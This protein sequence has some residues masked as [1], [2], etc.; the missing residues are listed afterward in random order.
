MNDFP[1]YEIDPYLMNVDDLVMGGVP[2]TH[3]VPFFAP[4][5]EHDILTALGYDMPPEI[6]YDWKEYLQERIKATMLIDSTDEIRNQV[7]RLSGPSDAQ[8]Y[9]EFLKFVVFFSSNGFFNLSDGSKILDW[10]TRQTKTLLNNIMQLNL[11]SVQAFLQCLIGLAM[12][13]NDKSAGRFLL[14]CDKRQRLFQGHTDQL[15]LAAVRFDHLTLV[16]SLLNMKLDVNAIYKESKRESTLLSNA[17]SVDMVNMLIQAGA[18]VNAVSPRYDRLI[19]RDWTPLFRAARQCP[20][21]VVRALLDAGAD[22]NLGCRDQWGDKCLSILT[23]AI[24]RGN[25]ELV[26]LLLDAGATYDPHREVLRRKPS[27]RLTGFGFWASQGS[28]EMVRVL[29]GSEGVLHS[30]RSGKEQEALSAAAKRGDTDIIQCLIA[31]GADLNIGEN[32]YD[33]YVRRQKKLVGH[34]SEEWDVEQ[35]PLLA[36]IEAGHVNV[37]KL[38]IDHHVDVNAAGAGTFSS[39]PLDTARIV[40]HDSISKLLSEAGAIEFS[41]LFNCYDSMEIQLAAIREDTHRVDTLVQMGIDPTCILDQLHWELLHL[42]YSDPNYVLWR[43]IFRIFMDVYGAFMGVYGGDYNIRSPWFHTTPLEIAVGIKDYSR[44]QWLVQHGASPLVDI[45]PVLAEG[46]HSFIE[47]VLLARRRRFDTAHPPI[48]AGYVASEIDLIKLMLKKGAILE[49]PGKSVLAVAI[50]HGWDTDMIRFLVTE[51]AEVNPDWEESPLQMALGAPYTTISH[52]V[53]DYLLLEGANVN[54]PPPPLPPPRP[55]ELLSP[56]WWS[57]SPQLRGTALQLAIRYNH[58]LAL[59]KRLLELGADINALAVP[60]EEGLAGTALQ[61]TMRI[62]PWRQEYTELIQ[63]LL[64]K[65]AD[66]NAP[67]AEKG[68]RTA[69]QAAVSWGPGDVKLI[70]LLLDNEADVNAP[71]ARV[72]GITALQGVSI[73]GN[74]NA[75]RLLLQRG[76]DVNAPGS[77]KEGRTALEGAAEQGRLDMVQLLLNNGATASETAAN[78]AKEEDYLVIYD[79]IMKNIR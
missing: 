66:V 63:L 10:I 76:A 78:F 32:L 4:V 70:N 38:L 71:P 19:W 53:V 12:E 77:E 68:G 64:S 43:R 50:A 65:G 59:I 42:S 52:R 46:C 30:I 73:E 61:L 11:L 20:I 29:L 39:N 34:L 26:R 40:G 37:V 5:H 72:R 55:R 22:V 60:G 47:L 1:T 69:L 17:D 75:A 28:S 23:N 2:F 33:G 21:E 15:L 49:S 51:G 35:P 48:D 9:F 25:A 54:A 74:M 16:R 31:A 58:D 27:Q 8:A 57:Q 79:L 45:S 6:T 44:A 56:P 18:D 14:D 7:Q 62:Y 67:A 3:R 41:R 13:T 36:A 24:E